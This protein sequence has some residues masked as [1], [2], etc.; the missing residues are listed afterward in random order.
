LAAESVR[1][2]KIRSG[3]S[4]AGRASLDPDERR[5]QRGGGREQP[6]RDA[7]APAVLARPG[8][9]VDQHHQA[10]RDR[11]GAGDVEVPVRSAARLSLRA[12]G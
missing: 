6:D 10:G 1:R 11:G 8:D 5:D 4:G 2:R 7:V 3:S 12:T 9:R